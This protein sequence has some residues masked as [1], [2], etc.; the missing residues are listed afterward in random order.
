MKVDGVQRRVL[1]DTGCTKCVAYISCCKAWQFRHVSLIAVNGQRLRS[2]GI[3]AVCLQ[4]VEGGRITVEV[5]VTDTKP[6]GFDFILGM[7]G[8]VALG[9][10]TVD[11]HRRVSFGVEGA[12]TCAVI[13]E[14]EIRLEERDF[15]VRF[16]P[17]TRSWTAQWKWTDGKEPDVLR[18]TVKEYS[19]VNGA[20]ASYEEELKVWGERG[21]LNW[22]RDSEIGVVP[23]LLTRRS[24][25]SYCE[26]LIGHFPVCGWF[27]VAAAL[28][29][30]KANNASTSWDDRISDKNLEVNGVPRHDPDL[31]RR[32]MSDE[33]A[34]QRSDASN[35]HE[36][37]IIRVPARRTEEA[38]LETSPEETTIGPRRSSRLR[39]PRVSTCCD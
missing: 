14:A 3:G 38:Q 27:R 16:S 20:R 19:P 7:N 9:G 29:K 5:I 21:N 31:R 33:A 34:S 37:M 18:I 8:I 10:V 11:D 2:L 13:N 30:R 6:L 36:E 35:S 32:V 26:K 22:R 25:F 15:V 17:M 24:V 4:P 39:R 12:V 23:K 28:V 1:V